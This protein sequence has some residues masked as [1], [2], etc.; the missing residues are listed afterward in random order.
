MTERSVQ[1][2]QEAGEIGDSMKPEQVYREYLEAFIRASN[3]VRFVLIA[4]VLASILVFVGAWNSWEMSWQVSRIS[5]LRTAVEYQLWRTDASLPEDEEER[6]RVTAALQFLKVRQMQSEEAIKALHG[7]Y[8]RYMV[9]HVAAV[10]VPFLGIEMDVNDLGIFGGFGF[11]IL[12]LWAAFS[13]YQ[14]KKVLEI[15]ERGFERLRARNTL[16]AR[17]IYHAFAMTQ[18]F[19]APPTTVTRHS[20]R[21]RWLS[22][23]LFFLPFLV[24]LGVTAYDIWSADRAWSV[25]YAH[26]WAQFICEALWALLIGVLVFVCISGERDIDKIWQRAFNRLY[27]DAGSS[28]PDV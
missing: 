5:H 1:A 2:A 16:D 28:N 25:N 12:L 13:V 11:T 9:E 4:I 23:S 8:Q 21:L 15:S 26:T 14:V 19:G 27:P 7:H 3:R 24:H 6:A 22:R 20:S 18:V 17:I 10:G